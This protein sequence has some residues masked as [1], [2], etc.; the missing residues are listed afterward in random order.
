M[1]DG[2]G[3]PRPSP[4]PGDEAGR[5]CRSRSSR[6]RPRRARNK[7]SGAPL[8][9][10]GPCVPSPGTWRRKERERLA[11]R[12]RDQSALCSEVMR[13]CCGGGGAGL[14]R[15]LGE[16]ARAAARGGVQ[17]GLGGRRARAPGWRGGCGPGSRDPECRS[18]ESPPPARSRTRV[19]HKV[20]G[21]PDPGSRDRPGPVCLGPP[22]ALDPAPG[23]T[24]RG[25]GA[26][27]L[28]EGEGGREDRSRLGRCTTGLCS[29]GASWGSG[30]RGAGQVRDLQSSRRPRLPRVRRG[31]AC[32]PAGSYRLLGKLCCEVRGLCFGRGWPLGVY[33]CLQNCAAGKRKSWG[34][35]KTIAQARTP[36]P[37]GESAP[38]RSVRAAAS[39]LGL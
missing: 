11:A 17:Y 29:V 33:S 6:S 7:R 35:W 4:G 18:G 12:L 37:A 31:G 1:M 39:Q 13:R 20:L 8:R 3:R 2:R 15:V 27:C 38:A 23:P 32:V 28:A 9:R 24:T 25:A 10:R 34:R 36:S 22:L 30:P 19:L 14:G 5:S 16:G 21:S 26:V